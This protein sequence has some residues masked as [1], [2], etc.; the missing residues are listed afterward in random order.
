MAH[1]T[2]LDDSN[3]VLEVIVV[4]N[5]VIDDLPFPESEPAGIAFL[6]EWSGGYTHWLQ[7]SYN[8]NFRKNYAAPGFT[9][10]QTLDGFIAPQPFP[11]WILNETICQ[12][13]APIPYPNDGFGHY[14][15]EPTLSWIAIPKLG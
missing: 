14:W 9:Y 5:T 7:T 6:T 13:E 11:S 8:S 3:T 1:F 2:K 12:W 15:D 10:N 4:N